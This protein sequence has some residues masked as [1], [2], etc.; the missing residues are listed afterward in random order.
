MQAPARAVIFDMD[1]T[2]TRDAFDFDLIRREIGLANEPILEAIGRMNGDARH[3]AEAILQ[4]HEDAA[5]A[6]S[7]LH[8]GAV[9]VVDGIRAAGLPVA[10]MTRNSARSV[11]VVLQR[12]PLRF[13]LVRTRDDG[14]FKPSPEPVFD[15]CKRLGV[16]ASD[17]WVVGD[18]LFDLQCGRAAGAV[19]VLL[20]V[21]DARPAWSDQADHVIRE[22]PELLVRLGL[23]A[24]AVTARQGN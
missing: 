23:R 11:A 7:E 19:T 16:T 2:L 15:I 5:A 10:L 8:P 9:E 21:D 13:D 12:Y 20:D 1:G 3:R 24:E 14:P 22:L 6:A 18:Y 4:R 17:S